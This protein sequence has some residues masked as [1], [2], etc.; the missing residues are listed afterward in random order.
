MEYAAS[1]VGASPQNRRQ[2]MLDIIGRIV[3]EFRERNIEIPFPQRNL[4][5]HSP[6]P[7]PL[8]TVPL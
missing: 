7:L 6:L 2:V 8:S 3:Q 1:D 4:H 5:V